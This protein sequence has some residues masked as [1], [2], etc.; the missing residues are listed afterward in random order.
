MLEEMSA[1]AWR[2]TSL[3][4]RYDEED[5]KRLLVD[6]SQI[7][8]QPVRLADLGTASRAPRPR[9]T[10][11]PRRCAGV[12]GEGAGAVGAD[13]ARD[14]AAVYLNVNRRELDGPSREMTTAEASGSGPTASGTRSSSTSG[15]LR[16][17]EELTVS[18]GTRPCGRS[19]GRAGGGAPARR[20]GR[21]S[22]APL[23][24]GGRPRPG[25]APAGPR[26]RSASSSRTLGLRLRHRHGRAGRSWGRVRA[27]P[28]R[29]PA[30]A[31]EPRSAKRPLPLRQ[32]QEYK[33]CH[34]PEEVP[35][36]E[37]R[38]PRSRVPDRRAAQ[39]L[40]R[41]GRGRAAR[42]DADP[43]LGPARRD[44]VNGRSR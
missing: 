44:V 18:T 6:V 17:F 10:S 28:G 31:H 42:A 21:A 3:R 1:R 8:L 5:L 20:P 43:R 11:W 25:C 29:A 34:E 23:A 40:H 4:E 12:R 37:D 2:G 36:M 13:P 38:V 39:E 24:V 41:G 32:R 30:A 27:A 14:R 9:P 19:P 33:K 35:T 22:I 16:M 7:V 26:R 15:G